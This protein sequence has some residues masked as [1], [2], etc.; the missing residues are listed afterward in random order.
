MSEGSV[1]L[2]M[3]QATILMLPKPVKPSDIPANF[4]PIS[5]LN[6]D[7]KLYTKVPV[8]SADPP[9]TD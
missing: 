1:P 8:K 6:T 3:L 4:R 9:D 2:E 5:L 7:I